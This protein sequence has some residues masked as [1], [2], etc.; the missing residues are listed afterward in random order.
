MGSFEI[1]SGVE[2][3][4]ATKSKALGT[5]IK[6]RKCVIHVESQHQ[7][8]RKQRPIVR[9]INRNRI[10][11]RNPNALIALVNLQNRIERNRTYQEVRIVPRPPVI[12]TPKPIRRLYV[13]QRGVTPIEHRQIGVSAVIAESPPE[14]VDLE[15]SVTQRADGD[16]R[17]LTAV[18]GEKELRRAAVGGAVAAGEGVR[19][20]V[21]RTA[22]EAVA[23]AGERKR[24]RD[25]DGEED[26]E[27][28]EYDG[29][30]GRSGR[31]LMH[32]GGVGNRVRIMGLLTWTQN[33]W[34]VALNAS[35]MLDLE[36]IRIID[37]QNFDTFPFG[38]PYA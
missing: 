26:E 18:A 31:D 5:L 11:Y 21:E 32:C 24:C 25:M 22:G 12:P 19:Q 20:V 29:D 9:K 7:S 1:I 38:I 33:R 27:E 23:A 6:E 4:L 16:L 37:L 14:R 2:S 34:N 30:G 8:L 3:T 10:E 28:E 17:R 36:N 35:T 15:D 13:R